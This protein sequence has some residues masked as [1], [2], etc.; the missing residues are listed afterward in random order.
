TVC[1]LNNCTV[2]KRIGKGKD[3]TVI[4]E[5]FRKPLDPFVQENCSC[6]APNSEINPSNSDTSNSY[7]NVKNGNNS[8]L[9][10]YR[11][12]TDNSLEIRDTSQVHVPDSSLSFM[13][14]DNRESGTGDLLFNVAYLKSIL[15]SISAAFPSQKNTGSSTV[16][17]SKLIKDPRLMKRE[18]SIGRQNNSTDLSDMLPFDKSLHH[19][20]SE[21]SLSCV[22]TS[23][24][25][26]PEV[27]PGNHAASTCLGTPSFKF[28]FESSQFQTHN[29]CSKGYDC[30]AASKTPMT[31]Q[32]KEQ[33][34]F[35]FPISLSNAVPEVENQK[36]IEEKSLSIQNRSNIPVLA[37][38]SSDP[39]NSYES[40]KACRKE[41]E[42]HISQESQSSTVFPLQQKG[43]IDE[44]IQSIGKMRTFSAPEDSSKHGESQ[45]WQKETNNFT[46]QT[47]IIPTDNCITL[48]QEYKEGGNL[49]SLGGNCE[50]ILKTQGLKISQSP[51]STTKNKDEL[52][53]VILDLECNLTPEI[54]CLSQKHHQCSLGYEDSIC[55]NFAVAQ[56]PELKLVQKTQNFVNM[57]GNFQETKDTLPAKEQLTDSVISS[58]AVDIPLDSSN[59]SITGEYICVQRKNEND[60]VS[61]ENIQ[62][63]CN[64]TPQIKDVR[65]HSLLYNAELNC[66]LHFSKFKGQ[67]DKENP[68]EA[69]DK[70]KSLNGS[71]RQD[72]HANLFTNVVERE[73]KNYNKVEIDNSEDIS[74]FNSI[75]EKKSIPAET[76]LPESEHSVTAIKRHAQND[77][78]SVEH[79]ASIIPEIT[80]SS[81]FVAENTTKQAASTTVLTPSTNHEKYQFKETCS[82]EISDWGLIEHNVSDCEH[83]M[84]KNKLE[85]SLDPS[86]NE[87][88][89]LQT[90][91]LGTEIEIESE[92]CNNSLFQQDTHTHGNAVH[93]ELELYE[94][95]KSRIDW[96]GLF[97]NINEEMETLGSFARREKSDQHHATESNCVSLSQKNESELHNPI[98]LPDVQITITNVLK[99]GFSPTGDSLELKDNF[100]EHFTK[101]AELEGRKEGKSPGF[102]I[103]SQPSGEKS[104]F[105]C[106][107]KFGNSIQELGL[108][109]ISSSI[110]HSSNLDHNTC[111]N[112]TYEKSVNQTFSTKPSDVTILNGES[113]LSSTKSKPRFNDTGNKNM[114]SRSSK[115]KLYTP[116]GQNRPQRDLRQHET[117]EKRRK[118]TSHDSSEHFSSL[119][120][121][122][123]KTFS[124]SERHIKSVLDI[125]SSEASLCKSKRLSRK[126]DKAVLHLKKAH[127]KVH[128]SLKLISKVGKKR[129]GPLPKAYAV[130]CNNFW[131][132]CD[133]QGDSFMSERRYSKHFLYKRKYEKQGEQ[134]FFGF[135]IDESVVQVS[136]RKPSRTDRASVAECLSSEI[137]SRS[138]SSSL[139]TFHVREFCDEEQHPESLAYPS[140]STNQSEY[141]NG[142]MKNAR[143]SKLEHF[144][145][146]NEC[147]LYPD[148]A[149][150]EKEHQTD[151][152]LPNSDFSKLENSSAH[153]IKD[154]TKENNS[155]PNVMVYKSNSASLNY[156]KENN[157]GYSPDKNDDA[158]YKA[159]TD[160]LA[161]VLDSNMNH[162]LNVDIYQQDNLPVS[163]CK[164]KLESI[165]PVGK[166]TVPIEIVTPNPLNLIASKR[167]NIPQLSSVLVTAG[168]EESSKFY[169]RRQGIFA[170]DSFASY[171]TT[172]YYSQM[173]GGKDLLKTKQYFSSNC[174]LI[175]EN[176]VNVTERSILALTSV[177]EEMRK[178]EQAVYK[179]INEGSTVDNEYQSQKNKI[180][181][182]CLMK[183]IVKS[184]LLRSN[185]SYSDYIYTPAIVGIKHKP[186]LYAY[187]D[188]SKEIEEHCL[189]NCTSHI[190]ELSRI[191]QRADEAASLRILEE[192]TKICQHILPLFVKAFERKQECSLEQILISRE[193]LVDQNLWNNYRLKLKPCAVDTLVELQM[194]METIQFIENKKRLLEGEPTFRSLLWYDETL[195]SE[196]LCR[197]R[198]FQL[199]SNFYP[200]FQGRLKYNA[201]CELKNYHNQ[202]VKYFAKIKKENSYY[203]FLKYKRQINEC[204]AVMKNYSDCFDFCLSVP[205]TCGVNFGDSLGDLETLRKTTLKLISIYGNSPKVL[206]YPGKNDHLWII[207]EMISSK[208]NFIKSNEEVNIKISL[209]GLEHICFDAAKNLVWK[210]KSHSFPKKQSQKNKTLLLKFNKCA[211]SKLQKIY[212]TL[213][214]N[215]NNEPVS[216]I[217]LEENA[218]IASRKSALAIIE[219]FKFN[220]TLLSYPDICCVSEILDQ[221]KSAD[222]KKL[223]NLTLRCT[224]HLE[225][226]KKYFQLL[227]ED[228]IDNIFVTEENVL[229]MLNSNHGAVVLKP[230][231][232]EIYIE[233]VMLSETIHFLKNL[234]AKK[235]DNQRFRGMLWFDLSLLPELVHCQEEMSFFL[236]NDNPADGLWKVIETTISELTK[237]LNVIC[238]YD[239]A[240]NCS[241]ALHLFSREL[242]ELT[243]IKKLLKESKYSVSTYIDFV[244][245]IATINYGNTVTQLE[246]NY[247]QFSILL[248][249]IMSV[250]Q[251]DLGKMSHIVK[252]MRTIEQMKIISAKDA[253]SSTRFILFQ[254]LRNRWNTFQLD[255]KEKMNTRVTK[256]EENS[257]QPGISVVQAPSIS[258]CIIKNISKSSKKRPITVD[259][260]EDSWEKENI[261]AVSSC[262]KQ[263][264][265]MK[266]V[267]ETDRQKTTFK[268]PRTTGSHPKDENKIRSSSS[269]ILKRNSVSLEMV[270]KQNSI[271][272]SLLPLKNLQDICTSK[273]ESKI[274]LASSLS[275][276]LGYLAGQQE[277]LN[278]IKKRNVNFSIAETTDKDCPFVPCNQKNIDGI[279]SEDHSTLSQKRHKNPMEQTREI[280]S[281][282]IKAGIDDFLAPN[283][284]MFSVPSSRLE[285][286]NTDFEHENSEV[287]DLSIKDYTHT[288][289]PEPVIIQDKIPARQVDTTQAVKPELLGKYVKNTSNPS[290]APFGSSG[291]STP[292]TA[293]TMQ[294]SL[295]E[296]DKENSKALTQK[297]DTYW[298]ELPQSACTPVYNSSEHSFGTSYP[299]HAWYVHHYN[300]N[301]GNTMT[302]TYQRMTMYEV[303]PPPP[304]MLTSVA[305]SVQNTHSTVLYSEYFSYF[306]EQP[307]ANVFIPGNGYIPSHVPNSYNYQQPIFSPFVPCQPSPQTAYPY[308]PNPNWLPEVPWTYAPWQQEPF[309]PRH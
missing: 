62:K 142:I 1:S 63:D 251:K 51:E 121:G 245:H 141:S 119:S 268:H 205:F 113:K 46:N 55:T 190:A 42:S 168:E 125:L 204:E 33:L 212:D 97:L 213:S 165:F 247:N 207:I 17:T 137:L 135:D 206:S 7:R 182:D 195:Y 240:V 173:C 209:Y 59:C 91:E 177:T 37:N 234:I 32:C 20:N 136:K 41:S 277:N 237:E 13:S 303:Q 198:G 47:K 288:N 144:V 259:K 296:Q 148:E 69:K 175:D 193:L 72:F 297:A 157:I 232:I 236:F 189:P 273:S 5:H 109:R 215:L 214:K 78:R 3:A 25:F 222:L 264:V 272:G 181:K 192:E 243:E 154:R 162:F 307:E 279:Y 210:E 200:A 68:Y 223:H 295:S 305:R 255:R 149:L 139:A 16:I 161:S 66:D 14:G 23:S 134:R 242:K 275:D 124:Q 93:E 87:N 231:A 74:T 163:I 35:S 300:S 187:P 48:Y 285:V 96:K 201:L 19:G 127:R 176:E 238:E 147:M 129:K 194:I 235:L 172:S 170:I 284:S 158:S 216:N 196:L 128:T 278:S 60:P 110:S 160:I 103:Y 270:K 138:V 174:F 211:F 219:N 290:S 79:L 293:Q 308:P 76:A 269:D 256:P 30:I 71:E 281:P 120:Q 6:K 202:L 50:K 26:S 292:N 52:D 95:L 241:Y 86:V 112:H 146:T 105:P 301:N 306:A 64:E 150:A 276:T 258:E 309:P 82:S 77:V 122:R 45:N 233:I 286:T 61:S 36:Y 155:Q 38:E 304:G 188:T 221:A 15:S 118:L 9:E 289:S 114:E 126:L 265:T 89:V 252:V 28:S 186:I 98:L 10:V 171:P 83:S 262:K 208:V 111:V 185:D 70:Y 58:S 85:E 183:K 8:V 249:N 230:E 191:L 39:Q 67:G 179:S 267:T 107:N 294:Y 166:Y 99:L 260:C 92:E 280:C 274:D 298:N 4:F 53:H 257:S 73:I 29:M 248:K 228:N 11:R 266:A 227:Q 90:F 225:I 27:V 75:L 156:I 180:P 140:Q 283:A 80:G 116:G 164:R 104:V 220:K 123:L 159:D 43:N 81:V 291:S 12:Q 217:G 133:L 117:Y 21:I 271:P 261:A 131:E 102:C 130:I 169:L 253:K 31:E 143:S 167:Y 145:E 94:D 40:A 178:T 152:K 254:M 229:D 244:P 302:H 106:E 57:T 88:S 287:L 263:K 246:H 54:E 299:H 224:D 115:R 22:S 199:Q 18:Q 218:L 84:D 108:G 226:L 101:S 151:T 239:E 197:P 132:S 44:Y 49:N 184:N 24:V 56:N 34:N 100:Y 282:N 2:A 203:A 250:P 65:D 153:D